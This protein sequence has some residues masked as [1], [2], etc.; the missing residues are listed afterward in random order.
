MT[1]AK[2]ITAGYA[3]GG[4]VIVTDRIAHHFDERVLVCG[5]TSYGHPLV[6]EAMV[7]AIES[8]RDEGL[9]DR[10]AAA[11]ARL[12]GTFAD[13]ARTRP[14]LGEVRG[15]GLLWA[16]EFCVPGTRD[17]LP[18]VTMSKVA[19]ALRRHH[20]HMHKRD[21]LVYFAPPLVITD[22]ELDDAVAAV[23]AAFDEALA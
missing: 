6:C 17:P 21:N 9:I 3:P 12:R 2:G 19:A 10:A 1:M 11:G 5:L 22:T 18:S 16:F 7:A 20:L 13:F 23:G 14:Y 15:V 8:Y 4:A